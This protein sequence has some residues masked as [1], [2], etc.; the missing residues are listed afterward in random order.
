MDLIPT[1]PQYVFEKP[2][3]RSQYAN[4]V[5]LRDYLIRISN[6]IEVTIDK[7]SQLRGQLAELKI[8]LQEC[9]DDL[10]D[11]ERTVLVQHPPSRDDRKTNKI[12][13]AYIRG[14]IEREAGSSVWEELRQRIRRL[15]SDILRKQA[16]KDA[17]YT[18]LEAAKLQ[19][20][21]IRSHL[22]FVKAER[23]HNA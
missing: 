9:E 22:A 3:I 21:N 1:N 11:F 5:V 15:R 8:E 16:E 14:I 6:N 23:E 10:E 20:D 7:I 13:D 2:K 12:L 18:R 17:C 4:P 19:S